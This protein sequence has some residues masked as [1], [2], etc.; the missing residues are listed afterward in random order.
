MEAFRKLADDRAMP[1][2]AQESEDFPLSEEPD[3]GSMTEEAPEGLTADRSTEGYREDGEPGRNNN[4][5]IMALYR[6]GKSA[7]DIARELE[8]GV[9]EVKLVIGLFRD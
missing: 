3:S 7:K 4:E 2:T 5:R 6:Q 9:G 1:E 8:L